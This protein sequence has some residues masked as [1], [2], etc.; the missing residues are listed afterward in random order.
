M[1]ALGLPFPSLNFAFDPDWSPCLSF[2]FRQ[3]VK[4]TR[5]SALYKRLPFWECHRDAEVA[6]MYVT[7]K[8]VLARLPAGLCVLARSLAC[9]LACLRLLCLLTCFLRLIHVLVSK[10]LIWSLAIWPTCELS[11][12][13]T[14]LLMSSRTFCIHLLAYVRTYALNCSLAYLP[15]C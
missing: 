4:L 6:E 8:C 11:Y 15:A 3:N 2:C 13:L 14:C 10:F 1:G 9:L 5:L 12:S 7:V